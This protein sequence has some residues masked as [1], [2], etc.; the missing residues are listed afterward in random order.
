VSSH[1][2]N[3]T[4]YAEQVAV[5]EI[6]ACKLVRL[7]CQ[8]QLDDL[9]RENFPY[10]FDAARAEKFCRF[11]ELLPHIKGPK[12]RTRI[13]LEPW[14]KFI[15]CCVF[16]WV[17]K[18][19]ERQRRFRRSYV[20]VPRG[21]AKSTISSAIGLGCLVLDEEG[22]AE[23]YSAATTRDQAKIVFDAAQQMARMSEGYRRKYGVQVNAHNICQLSSASKFE[24]LSAEANT[25]DGLNIHV[26]IVD[27]LHAHRTRE[28]YDV[29]ETGTGKRE[30]SLLW[31]IT[32]AGS[33]RAGICY[34]IRSYL[35]K[36]L[37]KV[38]EDDSFFG[39]IYSIDDDDEWTDPEIW[40]KANPNWGVSV[41]PEVIGQLA[42]KAMQ[43]PSAQNNFK[44]KHLCL[45]VN[46]DHAWMDMQRWAKCA[47]PTLDETD[48]AGQSCIVG[49]DLASKLDLLAKVKLFWKKIEGKRHYYVFGDYWTPEERV[50]QSANSQYKGWVIEGK[51][52]TCPG[53]TNDYDVVEDAIRADCKSYD[54]L[55]VAHDPY[56]AQQFVNH[57]MPEGIKMVEV[58]QMPKQLSEPMKELEAAVYDG[59]FHFNGDPIM[60][61][62]I[63]NVVCHLDKNDNLFPTKQTYEN[64][65]DPVTA[66]LTAL[67][68][69]MANDD[70]DPEASRPFFV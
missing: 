58:S 44:T 66:L 2:A 62:A 64:K 12:A 63:S 67:N 22:G 21:N 16:G 24:P 36:V 25:L 55:E 43:M 17:R 60:S 7:A 41:M 46:A 52:H 27:E 5:G 14:Q 61:W 15:L 28:V 39:I 6:P 23:I 70:I 56:Q 19:N 11:V 4:R 42:H 54:V 65:I 34:E 18:G 3:A 48:F 45:W 57:L 31:S 51:L 49:L 47:D 32:T 38:T 29:L 26:A 9:A 30:Q 20:E 10:I 69:V 68:R 53:E 13:I 40:K 50:E 1:V 8:R 35:T 59:R 37:N 33:N